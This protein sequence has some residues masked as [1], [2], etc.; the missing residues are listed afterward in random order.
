MTQQSAAAQVGASDPR[1]E[2]FVAALAAFLIER[3]ALDELAVHRAQR[4]QKQSGERFDLVLTRLG[5]LPDVELARLLAEFLGVPLAEAKDLPQVPL[6]AE[7]LQL[8]FLASNRLIPLGEDGETIVVATADPFNTDPIAAIGF[9]LGRPVEARLMAAS[10][11]ERAIQE[12]Y[13]RAG[14]MGP[15]Q[16]AGSGQASDEDVRRLEDLASEAPIIRLAHDLITRAVDMQASDIHVEPREDSLRVR[17]RLDGMLHTIETLPLSVRAAVTSRIKIMAQL[18][19]AERR[20]PQDGRIKT[21]VHGREIDLRV[22]TMPTL[23]G[24]SVVLRI[25]D[26]SSVQLDFQALGFAGPAHEAFAKLLDQPNGII[27]VTG[28]T[29][30]G[31]TTTLYTALNALNTSERKTFTVEDPIEYQLVGVNQIQVQPKIG[32]SF[33]HALRSILRQDPDII[34]VGEIRDLET[35]QMSIQASLTGHLVLST[36]HT[37]SAAATVT[38]LLDMGVADY[39]LSSTLTGV[40]AQRL[41]RR[42]C[43]ACAA[44]APDSELLL[45]RLQHQPDGITRALPRD[46]RGLRSKVGCKVCRN[47]GYLGRTTISELLVITDRVRRQILESGTEAAIHAAALEVGMITMFD[48]GLAKALRGETTIDEVLRVTRMN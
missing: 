33:A 20:L 23:C 30:S 14:A 40:L 13:G 28:P 44:P 37:N 21:T 45:E 18:N 27:L 25:L 17:Y 22:S 6:L 29:G 48:D 24:E 32:L 12:I 9:L 16:E 19:I 42:L 7:H 46:L 10:I 26:R 5:L 3:N 34:M 36:V 31:K 47:T 39:L 15:E 41:V 2:E 38:R 11:V 1:S 4:A 8:N 43:Q 35:A